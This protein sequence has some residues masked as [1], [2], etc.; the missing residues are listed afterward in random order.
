MSSTNIFINN[1]PPNTT[2][3]DSYNNSIIHKTKEQ[4][5][6]NLFI[7]II[8][9]IILLIMKTN[10]FFIFLI[11]VIGVCLFSEEYFYLVIFIPLFFGLLQYL[12]N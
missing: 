7:Y 10:I 8:I 9:V 4:Y 11:S 5:L 12:I 6:F 3:I 1:I 2:L